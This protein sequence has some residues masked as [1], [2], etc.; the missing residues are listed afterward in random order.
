MRIAGYLFVLILTA[1]LLIGL[2]GYGAF[3]QQQKLQRYQPVPASVS[4]NEVQP[5][6]L[7]GYEPA[8]TYTYQVAGKTYESHR[9]APLRVH[10]SRSWA[11]SVSRRVRSEGTTAFVN[12]YDPADAYLLPIG[13][14]R[15]YGLMLAGLTVFAL[16]LLPLFRGG[17][18]SREP[19]A[20]TGGPY[21]WYDL[22]PGGSHA[23]RALGWC[24]SALL[25]YLFGALIV[26]HYYLV[27]PPVY[28]LKSAVSSALFGVAGLWPIYKAFS[29]MDTASRLGLP[30]A[31]MTR[32][33]VHLN[34]PVIV[35]VEQPF[36]R[37][38]IVREMRVVLTCIRREGLGSVQYFTSSR[39][40]A[41]D[42]AVRAGEVLHG[43]CRFEIPEK[44]RHASTP[45]SRWDY[46]RTDWQIEVVVRTSRGQA[47]TVFPITAENA[48]SQA[49]AA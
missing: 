37:D 34:E 43:E 11:E 45:F 35:R 2:G 20:I 48:R 33:I 18:F 15:P 7:G 36:I 31:Q 28:E 41:E 1:G 44:K 26:G 25:W 6:R 5:S 29:A 22:T 30:K 32:K 19:V 21:D 27:I 16:G 38:G 10:G 14:F 9:V 3:V 42:R 39:I 13:R 23:D 17:V 47:G 40:V 4:S 8:V 12:P 24:A 49:K 46:P